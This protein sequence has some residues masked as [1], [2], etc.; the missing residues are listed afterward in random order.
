[1]EN[2]FLLIFCP[3]SIWEEKSLIETVFSSKHAMFHIYTQVKGF[4]P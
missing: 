3:Y 4:H 1:M 2:E